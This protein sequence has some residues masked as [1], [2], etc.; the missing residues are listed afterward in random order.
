MSARGRGRDGRRR[1][2]DI[3]TPA[4]STPATLLEGKRRLQEASHLEQLLCL[5]AAALLHSNER[6][7][8]G[9]RIL[10]PSCPHIHLAEAETQ[11]QRAER[12]RGRDALG[13]FE[14]AAAA[15]SHVAGMAGLSHEEQ[16]A[17]AF[18]LVRHSA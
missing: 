5:P 4:P 15:F 12:K 11:Q 10:A 2:A 1:Q 17:A 3:D 8:Q 13:A 16:Q 7:G 6:H 9:R 18:G 14:A